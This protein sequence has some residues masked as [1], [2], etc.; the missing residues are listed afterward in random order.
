MEY[1]WN[2][3]ELKDENLILSVAYVMNEGEEAEPETGFAGVPKSLTIERV[4]TQD[5]KIDI[6]K[7]LDESVI[8]EVEEYLYEFHGL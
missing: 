1:Y 7:I 8:D 5:S 6:I 3:V 4:H 2:E